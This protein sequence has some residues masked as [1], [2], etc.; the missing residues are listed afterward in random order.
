MGCEEA[1]NHDPEQLSEREQTET[2]MVAMCSNCGAVA[3]LPKEMLAIPKEIYDEETVPEGDWRIDHEHRRNYGRDGWTPDQYLGDLCCG[4]H[5]WFI[6]YDPQGLSLDAAVQPLTVDLE[7]IQE[8]PDLAQQVLRGIEVPDKTVISV[9]RFKGKV[10]I[11]LTP[12]VDPEYKW[13]PARKLAESIQ[14]LILDLSSPVTQ[15]AV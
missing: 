10:I 8:V 3:L 14:E 1:K 13:H 5:L 12:E 9:E 4:A 11:R 7:P 6:R 2:Y 15:E